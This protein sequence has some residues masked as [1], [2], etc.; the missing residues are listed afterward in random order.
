MRGFIVGVVVSLIGCEA[1]VDADAPDDESSGS[2]P[3]TTASTTVA[4]GSTS[5][6]S[7]TTATPDASSSS[8]EDGSSSSSSGDTTDTGEPEAACPDDD[9]F[10]EPDWPEGDPIELG[11]DPAAL[12]EAAT[13]AGEHESRCLVVIRDGHLVFERYWLDTTVDTKIKSYSIAKSHASS[14]VGIA[15]AQGLLGSVDDPIV[16][17]LPEL[18]GTPKENIHIFDLLTM[19]SGVYGGVLDEYV[20]LTFSSDQTQY[21]IDEDPDGRLGAAWQY[22]N[23]G[24]QLLEPVLR[25]V[26]GVEVEAYANEHLWAP[27]GMDAEWDK[28]GEGHALTY[29]NVL[30]SCRDQARFGYLYLK[31][32]CWNGERVIDEA[33]I[34]A[35]TTTSQ[36]HNRGYGYLFWVTGQQPTL[37]SVSLEEIPGGL[38][39]FAPEG[40]F[41]AQGLG[42]Q[43]IEI[44]PALDMVVVRT[45]VAPLDDP[46][47]WTDPIG[48]VQ[49]LIAGDEEDV[50]GNTLEMI[51]DGVE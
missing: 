9:V 42:G 45:G 46:D 41:A 40:T 48:L 36:D 34:D 11:I 33:Y 10:P 24:V 14:L 4:E 38:H 19:T 16:E 32:G 28:D 47:A 18:A 12:E 23:I 5:D 31:R 39:P 3:G 2:T 43:M 51:L 30:A 44:I 27:I 29:Q 6:S 1:P 50:P 15:I 25:T 17:Y 35:A 20:F 22:S 7:S 21:A 13:Y 49:E 8:T 26:S 37:G